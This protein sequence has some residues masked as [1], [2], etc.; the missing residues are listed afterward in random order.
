MNHLTTLSCTA[1]AEALAAKASVPGGGGAAAMVGALSAALC[2]MVGNFTAG[3]KKYAAYEADIQ[4]ILAEAEDLRR[5]LLALVD[6]DAAG[7]E[8]LAK[9]YAIPKEDPDRDAVMEKATLQACAAPMQMLFAC[10]DVLVLLEELLEKGSRLL[11]ADVG[12]GA[13]LCRAA[14][15]S[16]ALSVFVNTGTL[17]SRET[18]A[19]LEQ[20]VDRILRMYLPMAERIAASVTGYI[21]K[22]N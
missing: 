19:E 5:C 17:K 14:M 16:A 1:F 20:Q 18:A 8:P 6:A 9:A 15:E 11:L 12:C 13:Y 3:K 7:F 22:E 2:S 21:R 4:R 10:G